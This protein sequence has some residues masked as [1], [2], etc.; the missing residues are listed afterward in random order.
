MPSGELKP[1]LVSIPSSYVTLVTF[2][3]QVRH[4]VMCDFTLVPPPW[5]DVMRP[6]NNPPVV[7]KDGGSDF[8]TFMPQVRHDVAC[9][10]I[11]V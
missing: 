7:A 4:D 2:V 3:P 6:L 11:F 8:V 9:D 10:F 1:Q 5:H